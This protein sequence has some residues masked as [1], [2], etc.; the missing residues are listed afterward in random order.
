MGQ[1]ILIKGVHMSGV[2]VSTS[3]SAQ[4]SVEF[5]SSGPM[6]AGQGDA[7][8]QFKLGLSYKDQLI[9]TGVDFF[10]TLKK[11]VS[12]F[13]IAADQGSAGAVDALG[14][15]S[16]AISRDVQGMTKE[17]VVICLKAA[18]DRKIDAEA[19]YALGRLHKESSHE[20]EDIIMSK[21]WFRIAADRGHAQAAFVL[22]W[23][24]QGNELDVPQNID[25]MVKWWRIA[26]N[27]GDPTAINWLSDSYAEGRPAW[28]IP[29]DV[30][31]SDRLI[32]LLPCRWAQAIHEGCKTH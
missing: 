9:A 7:E 28:G 29:Q 4:Q 21:I 27:N 2:V 31:E 12:C 13:Q 3:S 19:A 16:K 22:G 20:P 15:L 6:A 8:A 18:A 14:Q 24:Y 26:A 17:D 30:R 1:Y 25:E 10:E 5:G 23:N 32:R 11:V